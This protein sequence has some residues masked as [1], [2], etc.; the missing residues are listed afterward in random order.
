[1][2]QHRDGDRPLRW[3]VLSTANIGRKVIGSGHGGF[4]AVASRRRERAEA[5]A[6]EHGIDRAH[7]SYEELLADPGIDA[8][9][10]PLPNS[11][12]VE[13]SVRALQAGKHVLCEKPMS[14]RPEDVERAFDVAEREG[15]VLTE[16]FMWRHHPQLRR[17]RE[18]IEDGVIGSLRLVR[19]AF[20]FVE[21]DPA[22]IRLQG[23]LDG[24]GLMDVG[25]YCVSGLRALAGEPERVQAEQVTGGNG[26]DVALVATLRF[27]GDVLGTLDCGL[28][29]AAHDELEAIGDGGALFLDDP[30]HGREA[31]IEVRRP[32]GTTERVETGPAN[33]Y[34]LEL[35]DFEAAVRGQRPPLL[36][37]EDAVAQ[38]RTIAAIY[39]SAEEGRAV[40]PAVAP[41][42]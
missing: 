21:T 37:R 13:W 16:A 42:S 31:V 28:S 22:D 32:D 20:S 8:V 15:R 2:Q 35:A 27:A 19:A 33:S 6:R 39:R 41:A 7:G 36:G 18:L 3:G 25:C 38:A 10:I 12:H 17:A 5:F 4:V 11:L 14:R 29:F 23:D 34:A 24:G 30:W 1:M 26:V 9:Y 40:E